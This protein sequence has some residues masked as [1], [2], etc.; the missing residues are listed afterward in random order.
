MWLLFVAFVIIL[1]FISFLTYKPLKKLT[2][3]TPH[4]RYSSQLPWGAAQHGVSEDALTPFE[5][6]PDKLNLFN[7]MLSQMGLLAEEKLLTNA[8]L[9]GLEI[10]SHSDDYGKV[11][12]EYEDQ[13]TLAE[14]L[15]RVEMQLADSEVYAKY[16]FYSHAIISLQDM[17]ESK[18]SETEKQTI[19]NALDIYT[20]TVKALEKE[21]RKEFRG[22]D[23]FDLGTRLDRETFYFKMGITNYLR[24]KNIIPELDRLYRVYGVNYQVEEAFRET[25]REFPVFQQILAEG[26][27]SVSTWHLLRLQQ[28]VHSHKPLKPSGKALK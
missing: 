20:Q 3:Q 19:H 15:K 10:A 6:A 11:G 13:T 9:F 16:Q 8:I 25:T 7:A 23:Q 18:K 28:F 4:A 17:L 22:L 26:L 1:L 27:E 2:H 5:G 12:I 21:L 14:L 24:G